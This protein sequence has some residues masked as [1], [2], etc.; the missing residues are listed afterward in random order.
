MLRKLLVN[1]AL[2]FVFPFLTGQSPA[3]LEDAILYYR[4]LRPGQEI[5][6]VQYSTDNGA[7]RCYKYDFRGLP[8]ATIVTKDSI[9]D[10]LY[11]L[12]SYVARKRDPHDFDL[13]ALDSLQRAKYGIQRQGVVTFLDKPCEIY[14]IGNLSDSIES[15]EVW[16]Y[17]GLELRRTTTY[18]DGNRVDLI[19]TYIDENP[20]ISPETFTVPEHFKLI[21]K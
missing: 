9:K 15:V 17:E 19:A 10:V 5:E 14:E 20:V 8:Y 21:R 3:G 2:F 7:L 1:I 13:P 4:Y 12:N 11:T 16:L 18:K 6:L